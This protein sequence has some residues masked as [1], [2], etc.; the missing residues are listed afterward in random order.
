[1]QGVGT[2]ALGIKT[3]SLKVGGEYS[4]CQRTVDV[5]GSELPAPRVGWT[6]LVS[7]GSM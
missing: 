2:D 1:M 3:R 5:V 4:K 7:R 6:A